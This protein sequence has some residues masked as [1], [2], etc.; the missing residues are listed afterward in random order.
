MVVYFLSSKIKYILFIFA[1]VNWRHT[2]VVKLLTVQLK[3]KGGCC[4]NYKISENF[5]NWTIGVFA[6]SISLLGSTGY[7]GID[8]SV[9]IVKARLL[10][11]QTCYKRY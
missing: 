1:V 7:I 6:Y 8:T 5:I 9:K 2:W 10:T 4:F 11:S 3:Y